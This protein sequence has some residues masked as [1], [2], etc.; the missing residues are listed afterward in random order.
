MSGFPECDLPPPSRLTVAD[1][2]ST[3]LQHLDACI[4]GF[5]YLNILLEYKGVYSMDWAAI[6]RVQKHVTATERL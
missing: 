1:R 6:P 3:S 2:A 5:T 4:T